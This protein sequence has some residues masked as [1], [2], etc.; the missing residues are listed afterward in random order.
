MKKGLFALLLVAG[1]ILLA[2][3]GKSNLLV[4][5]WAH[6]SFVYTFNSDGTCEYDVSGSIM[7][8]TYKTS[9]NKLSILYEGYDKS[10]D[11]TY[12]VKGNKLS[13]KDSFGNDTVYTKK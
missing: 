7:K 12:S 6:G 4:G 1:I 10:L 5:K 9:G 13:I 2:G 8:C 3:C 11:T